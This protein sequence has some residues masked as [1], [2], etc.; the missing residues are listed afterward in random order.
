[1]LSGYQKMKIQRL[2]SVMRDGSPKYHYDLA[3]IAAGVFVD[4]DIAE[5]YPRARKYEPLDTMVIINNDAVDI[6]INING[7]GSDLYFVIPAG[8][9]RTIAREEVSAIWQVR[10]TNLDAV[11]A[12]T[13]NMIDIEFSRSPEDADSIARMGL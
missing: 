2:K 13:V 8:V 9:I 12:V 7:M 10:I 1:M 11:S 5:T 4:F 6:G 3:V